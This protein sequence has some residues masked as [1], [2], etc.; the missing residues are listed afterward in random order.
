MEQYPYLRPE[1]VPAT[2]KGPPMFKEAH[3]VELSDANIL[4][5]SCGHGHQYGIPCRHLFALEP[6]YD[7]M[8]IDYRYQVSFSYYGFHPDHREVTQAFIRR[9]SKEHNGIRKKTLEI[10]DTVPFLSEPRPYTIQQ[11]LGLFESPIPIC[12]NYSKHEYPETYVDGLDQ[13]VAQGDFT[14]ESVANIYDNDGALFDLDNINGPEDDSSNHVVM[15]G[16]VERAPSI[17]DAQLISKFKS[18]L[19][20]HKSDIAKKALWEMLTTTEQNQRRLLVT[21]SPRLL[22]NNDDEFHSLHLP[23]DQTRESVQC[24]HTAEAESNG[25]NVSGNPCVQLKLVRAVP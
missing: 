23:I 3:V 24:T 8:D 20:C 17:T 19:S 1:G 21:E 15:T 5:C 12:W 14:Q 13:T 18:C 4:T 7:I 2:F 6:E 11:I 25:K 16:M 22:G 9:Q 10:V